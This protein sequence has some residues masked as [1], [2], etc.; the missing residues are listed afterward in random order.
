MGKDEEKKDFYKNSIEILKE[1]LS[2]ERNF[3]SN[4][5]NISSFMYFEMNEK[6]GNKI[7]WFGF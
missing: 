4:M 3:V 7:N 6:F 1:L 2:K 5:A